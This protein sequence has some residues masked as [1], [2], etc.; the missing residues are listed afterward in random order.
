MPLSTRQIRIVA[1]FAGLNVLLALGGWMALVSPQRQNAATAAAAAD[2]AQKQLDALTG[3]GTQGPPKQ[4]A[5]HTA[6]LYSLDTALPSQPD[7]PGLLLELARVASA[8]GVHLDGITPQA[9]QANAAG[10]TVVPINLSVTGTY[11]NLTNFLRTL[12]LLVSE[13]GGRLIANGPLFA[14]TSASLTSG[15]GVEHEVPATVGLEAFYY[16]VT[17]GATAP[18]STTATDTTTTTGG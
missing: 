1:V 11:F 18:A 17:A 15:S 13:K 3:Q 14:V 7:Q 10:Y 12:R 5:I 9:A 8:S 16:G 4:P 2:L 6:G